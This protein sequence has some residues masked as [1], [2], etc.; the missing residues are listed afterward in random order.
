MH[1]KDRE[2]LGEQAQKIREIAEKALATSSIMLSMAGKDLRNPE[3]LAVFRALGVLQEA[4][5]LGWTGAKV[6][7]EPADGDTSPYMCCAEEGG[8]Q[9]DEVIV[10]LPWT[11]KVATYIG[12]SDTCVVLYRALR[13]EPHVRFVRLNTNLEGDATVMWQE[14]EGEP[15][16]WQLH[17]AQHA[18]EKTYREL[19]M[20][21]ACAIGWVWG[22]DFAILRW[23]RLD[24]PKVG[25][26]SAMLQAGLEGY[27]ALTASFEFTE[28]LV[29]EALW[30]VLQESESSEGAVVEEVPTGYRIT[31]LQ[32]EGELPDKI[33]RFLQHTPP[34]LS[35]A[36]KG[37]RYFDTRNREG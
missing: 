33:R 10:E 17:A 32:R 27:R 1:D 4:P 6:A 7:G 3:R 8:G 34:G 23:Y 11:N 24:G 28:A 5:D 30:N 2:F 18:A 37:L 15:L 9:E 13:E 31:W 22:G 25:A 36:A 16:R 29:A 19:K 14:I 21:G 20:S 35:L 12:L 26:V